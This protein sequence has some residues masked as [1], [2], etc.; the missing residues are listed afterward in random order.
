ML[1]FA[2]FTVSI[3]FSS[4]RFPKELLM[5]VLVK[6]WLD[7]FDDNGCGQDITIKS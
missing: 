7:Y 3:L 6:F 5:R 2:L 1:N 4:G